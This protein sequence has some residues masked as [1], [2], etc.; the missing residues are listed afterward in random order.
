MELTE[1]DKAGLATLI[2][3]PVTHIEVT[4]EEVRISMKRDKSEYTLV[5][6]AEG[7]L[8]VDTSGIMPKVHMEVKLYKGIKR[9]V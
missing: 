6:A 3:S 4:D 7:F 2:D 9:I 1:A 8:D 5:V